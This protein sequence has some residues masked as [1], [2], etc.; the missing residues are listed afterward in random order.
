M[1]TPLDYDPAIVREYAEA[2][3]QRADSVALAYALY[4]FLIGSGAS[5]L[6]LYLIWGQ[7]WVIAV[8]LG[9]VG[10]WLGKNQGDMQASELRLQAQRAL[11]ALKI[12][13]NTR[14]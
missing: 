3:Y 4:G 6:V 5:F 13:E 14:S 10:A 1:T 12:E 8:V 7:G 11:L 9:M 2:L